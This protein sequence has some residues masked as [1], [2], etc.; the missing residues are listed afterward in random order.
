MILLNSET[1]I[2]N[3]LGSDEKIASRHRLL[4]RFFRATTISAPALTSLLV[5][6]A[7]RHRLESSG[8]L[9][10]LYVVLGAVAAML[11]TAACLSASAE[12]YVPLSSDDVTCRLAA[13]LLQEHQV[14]REIRDAIVATGRQ[15]YVGDYFTMLAVVYR[16]KEEQNARVNEEQRKARCA[17]VH[18]ISG[19]HG[20][21]VLAT[22]I[23]DKVAD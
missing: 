5:W 13:N 19:P 6:W 12:K 2:L 20:T 15:L 14:A 11:I 23:S 21:L 3:K 10:D 9:L 16:L 17:E 1:T 22:G 7:V 4:Q 8:S 18:G